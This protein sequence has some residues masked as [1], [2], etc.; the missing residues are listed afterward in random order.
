MARKQ[1][2]QALEQNSISHNDIKYDGRLTSPRS[3]GVYRILNTA[4]VGKEFRYGN[5]PV[6]Q[7][8]LRRE[9]GDCRLVYLF[10]EREHA[11]RMQRILNEDGD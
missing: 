5:H 10:L 1:A 9:F 7:F 11:L 2:I 3:Y 6:R 8:E 4:N